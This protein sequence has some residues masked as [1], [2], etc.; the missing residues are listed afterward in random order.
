MIDEDMLIGA[1]VMAG[2]EVYAAQAYGDRLVFEGAA[3]PTGVAYGDVRIAY[4]TGEGYAASVA[5]LFEAAGN[6][7]GD[8]RECR[9]IASAEQREAVARE[10]RTAVAVGLMLMDAGLPDD[11]ALRV[12]DLYPEW[13][14]GADYRAGQVA[15]DG[16]I[17]RCVQGHASQAGWEPHA[18][19]AL[20]A[21][22]A[23][24]GDIEQWRRPT[25]A[26]DAYGV[27]DTVSHLGAEWASLSDGNVWEQGEP[28]APWERR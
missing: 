26:H 25:G 27:G 13:E 15:R 18:T 12:A 19:P 11:A 7:L 9:R 5:V 14:A 4:E 6:P 22:I 28:G 10:S 17:Y 21:E 1:E 24:A 16:G 2:G 23:Y 3:P 8:A 20:W